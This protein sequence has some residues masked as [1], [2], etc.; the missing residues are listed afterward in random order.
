MT[1]Y[2]ILRNLADRRKDALLGFLDYRYMP[3]ALG[4]SLTWLMNLQVEARRRGLNRIVQLIHVDSDTPINRLQPHISAQN[5]REVLANLFPAFLCSPMADTIHVVENKYTFWGMLG[6]ASLGGKPNWPGLLNQLRQRIDYASHQ[7]INAYYETTGDLPRLAAPRG[8][9]AAARRFREQHLHDRFVVTVNI[10]QRRTQL[11]MSAIHRDSAFD[12]WT[13]FFHQAAERYPDTVFAIL[14]DYHEW[15]R[16]LFKA[17]NVVMPRTYGH[18]LGMDLALLFESD[19]FM[20]TSS[21]F[22]AAATFSDI[23]YVITNF[24]HAAAAFTG[25]PIDTPR[26]PFARP[27]QTLCWNLET[28]DLLMGHFTSAHA[29]LATGGGAALRRAMA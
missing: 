1:H 16:P 9:A 8:H 27:H 6:A 3:Y 13:A 21:G 28:P 7:R 20:G 26:Y 4:D 11:H 23:P 29:A 25:I 10:R 14:G 18:G 17:G 5:Y 24:E 2:C 15:D 19:L 12:A 22:S